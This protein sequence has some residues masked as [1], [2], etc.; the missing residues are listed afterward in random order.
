MPKKPTEDI[1]ALA[2]RDV[3]LAALRQADITPTPAEIDAIVGAYPA[4]RA[5]ADSLY[6]VPGVEYEVP[7][8]IF[9]PRF[10]P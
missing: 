8:M 10:T 2:N 6:D 1:E 5:A 4:M 9:D 3:V 7:A